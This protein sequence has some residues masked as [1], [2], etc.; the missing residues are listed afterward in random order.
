MV[1]H[2]PQI[3]D[4]SPPGDI[5][6]EAL[7][8]RGMT[9]AELARRM[10]FSE[11]HVSQLLNAKVPL[12]MDVALQLEQVLGIPAQLWN[13]IE[14]NYRSEQLRSEQRSGYS[15]F[16]SWM[17]RFPVRAM[18]RCGYLLADLGQDVVSRVEALLKFFGI[19]SPDAWESQWESVTA[20]FRKASSF[21]PDKPALT[22][23]LRKGELEAQAIRCEAYSEAAFRAT[24]DK[25]RLLTVELPEVFVPKATALCASAGVAFTLVPSLPG[26][27]L[28]GA[29]RWFG[30][31]KAAIHLS[32]RHKSDD[33][34][35]FS[36]FHEACHVLEHRTSAIYIDAVSQ[37]DGDEQER[38]ANEFA[39]DFLIPPRD[40]ARIAKSGT[41]SLNEIKKFAREIGI[42]P[43]IVVG[44]L[45]FDGR[46]P[47][48]N[49]NGL[50]QRFKWAFEE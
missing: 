6:L 38:C 20:R 22:A 13:A 41:L 30:T 36:F 44:R 46:M 19:T 27:A 45:Q 18:A 43:G 3:R 50:K 35:W 34:L 32:L 8:E 21:D 26:L 9:S 23:W 2:A 17:R 14:F 29:T 16:A 7:E 11:K 31:Q 5:L 1:E 48:K 25:V 47:R 28:N 49:G 10:E 33:Q 12:T 40:Y 39:R 4:L 42:A 24:L 15:A 37:A